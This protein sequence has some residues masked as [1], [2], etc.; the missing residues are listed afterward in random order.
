MGPVADCFLCRT[1]GEKV[2]CSSSNAP[3]S[4]ILS[5]ALYLYSLRRMFSKRPISGIARE[6]DPSPK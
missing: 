4:D 1:P 3:D 2:I 5:G 6:L